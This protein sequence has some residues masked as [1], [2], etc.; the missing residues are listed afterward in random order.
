MCASS[1]SARLGS[2][3][4]CSLPEF[5]GFRIVG[6]SRKELCTLVSGFVRRTRSRNSPSRALHCFNKNA[7]TPACST[8]PIHIGLFYLQ[9]SWLASLDFDKD[10]TPFPP[11][12]VFPKGK[13]TIIFCTTALACRTGST[14]D[15]DE[16]ATP[17]WWAQSYG[18]RLQITRLCDRF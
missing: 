8:A 12:L 1:G 9:Q 2:A 4:V 15:E 18:P 3:V 7:S 10:P 6:A 11:L 16:E 17:E 13:R 5:G 14:F